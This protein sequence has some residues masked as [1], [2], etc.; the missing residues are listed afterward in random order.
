MSQPAEKLQDDGPRLGLFDDV[1]N[2]EYHGGP[3]ISKSGLDLINQ[4]PL[5][6]IT[7]KHHPR[8]STPAMVIGSAFHALVL[9]PDV[10]AKEYTLPPQGAPK[11]PTSAQ[12]N[13]QNPSAAAMR[14]ID[15]WEQWNA[16]NE[17]KIIIENKTGDDPFWQPGDWD[18]LHYM[19]DAVFEHPYA[20]ILLDPDQG[21]AEQSVYWIDQR[22]KKLCK[23]RPDFINEVHKIAVDLKSTNDASYSEF[24]KSS[25]K[26]RYH[27]QDP[28]YSDGLSE[29]GHPIGSFVFVAVEKT[30]PWGIGIYKIPPEERRIGRIEYQRNLET[31]AESHRADEWPCYPPEIRDLVLP[32]WGLKGRVS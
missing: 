22:T 30:P 20:S 21:K 1:S 6:Y 13:S 2:A 9:E 15:Y 17:G 28:F 27:V 8:P 12:L 32:P 4:S 29:I 5:H 18:R 31:Y 25:A 14:S 19:R 11:R 10:F 23:C 24:A 26:F 7:N 3:G 16:E